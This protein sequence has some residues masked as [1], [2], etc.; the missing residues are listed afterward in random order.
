MFEKIPQN[1]TETKPNRNKTQK[2]K[3]EQLAV[4][5]QRSRHYRSGLWR[6]RSRRTQRTRRLTESEQQQASE[7]AGAEPEPEAADREPAAS[8]AEPEGKKPCLGEFGRGVRRVW[9]WEWWEE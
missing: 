3:K 2:K 4:D 7:I 6:R 8:G 5:T 1:A 9:G